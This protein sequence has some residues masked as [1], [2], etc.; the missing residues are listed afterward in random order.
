ME[1]AP[2]ASVF[3]TMP[4]TTVR[5]YDGLNGKCP[6][7]LWY[8]NDWSLFGDTV[9]VGGSAF[10]EEVRYCLVLSVLQFQFKM[11]GVPTSVLATT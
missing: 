9:W 7:S 6:P 2:Q 4:F 10:L 11:G 1:S 5:E 8:L 3:P